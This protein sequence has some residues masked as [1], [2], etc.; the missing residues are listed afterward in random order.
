MKN[1]ILLLVFTTISFAAICEEKKPLT[2]SD[3]VEWNRITEKSISNDGDFIAIKSQNWQGAG[4]LKIYDNKTKLIVEFKNATKHKFLNDDTI[5]FVQEP[6]QQTIDS[7]ERAKSKDKAEQKLVI[8]DLTSKKSMVIDSLK[9]YKSSKESAIIAYTRG[10]KDNK[11]LYITN[12]N[13]TIEIETVEKYLFAKNGEEL[14]FSTS[15]STKNSIGSVDLKSFEQKDIYE[16]SE[17][18]KSITISEDGNAVAFV[19]GEKNDKSGKSNKLYVFTEQLEEIKIPSNSAKNWIINHHANLSFTEDN[20]RLYFG[21]SPRFIEQDTLTLKSRKAVVDVWHWNEP[22]LHTQ[23]LE[24]KN[25]ELKR[26]YKAVALLERGI[27]VQLADKITP[28]VIVSKEGMGSVVLAQT[29]E[30]Y[31]ISTMWQYDTNSD[32]YLI[33]IE[34]GEKKLIKKKINIRA[35][36]SPNGEYLYWYSTPN[37]TWNSYDIKSGKTFELASPKDFITYNDINDI[38]DHPSQQG[39]AGWEADDKSL[40]VYGKYDIWKLDP[41]NSFAPKNLTQN[42]T[43][44][45]TKYRVI[46]LDSEKKSFDKKERL[47]LSAFNTKTKGSAFATM[48]ISGAKPKILISELMRYSG[49]VKSKESNKLIFTKESF[50]QS[51]EIYIT[52]ITFKKVAQLSDINP[53]QSKFNW[54]TVEQVSWVSLVGDT[55]QGLLFKPENFDPNKKYPLITNFYEKE[56]DN[57]FSHRTPEPHRSTIDYHYYTSNGYVVFNPDIKYYDGHPGKSCY[58]AVMPGIDMIIEQGYIDTSRIGAQGHSW[59][60]YQVAHLA[61]KTDRFAA[62]ESGAPVVNMLSAYG[63]IRWE[64]GRNR[65]FQYEKGQ[66]RIGKTPWEAPELYLANSPLMEMDKVTTPIL[67]MHNDHDGHV[68]WEQA[69]EFFIALRR[70]QQPVWMLNYNG[71]PHWPTKLP[72]KLDFQI[73]MSQFFN[74][75]LKGAEMP[76]WMKT[77]VSA[78]NKGN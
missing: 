22:V 19:V 64:T 27:S 32:I 20:Q 48:P 10:A 78:V 71:E 23:Q 42:G 76:K 39:E 74:H 60:G 9:S 34:S 5:L 68:P 51:P 52:D 61:T 41:Q 69:V 75:Y 11:I 58:D 70:L 55:L 28:T 16:T 54:G 44:T 13:R 17:K 30:P 77:G 65:A 31:K 1:L 46:R 43:K 57:R 25:K 29:I 63:G 12:T 40:I 26:S 4:I 38:P 8:Y 18:I 56:S 6:L 53:Q 2:W 67:I 62:I 24:N 35:R 33:D 14:L 73:R 49:I 47:L 59:G 36:I 50:E 66:S 72:N 3:V 45:Q 7:L 37:K 21:T 15:D